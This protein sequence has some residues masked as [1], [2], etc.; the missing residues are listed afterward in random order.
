M[1]KGDDT[2][3][4]TMTIVG[5]E[6]AL[7]SVATLEGSL[8]A[9]NTVFIG[10]NGWVRSK[11]N[12]S[13]TD[14]LPDSG[15]WVDNI[16]VHKKSIL[17]YNRYNNTQ[18]ASVLSLVVKK[19]GEN[20]E[21][22]IEVDNTDNRL[23]IHTNANNLFFGSLDNNQNLTPPNFV[24]KYNKTY[25]I[26]NNNKKFLFS[27]LTNTPGNY[28]ID[29]ESTLRYLKIDGDFLINSLSGTW[30]D[31]FIDKIEFVSLDTTDGSLHESFKKINDINNDNTEYLRDIL[32]RDEFKLKF[33]DNLIY[34]DS[35]N[36]LTTSAGEGNKIAIFKFS[37]PNTDS[38]NNRPNVGVPVDLK[39]NYTFET[40]GDNSIEFNSDLVLKDFYSDNR[41]FTVS[42]LRDKPD[43]SDLDEKTK[44]RHNIVIHNDTLVYN[45][46]DL[47]KNP[48]I[49]INDNPGINK[50]FLLKYINK[51]ILGGAFF[52]LNGN[53][54]EFIDTTTHILKNE[55]VM[56]VNN[57][58]VDNCL[59]N[60]EFL[61]NNN[62]IGSNG[63][64]TMRYGDEI[65][66]FDNNGNYLYYD[67]T[68]NIFS[69]TNVVNTKTKFTIKP[70]DDK[71]LGKCI[72]TRIYPGNNYTFKTDVFY[73]YDTVSNI[74][75]G[76][77]EENKI[78]PSTNGLAIN[79]NWNDNYNY[80]KII[81]D[82]EFLESTKD[83]IVS[84]NTVNI[85]NNLFLGN[86]V[87]LLGSN[88]ALFK[89]PLVISKGLPK[90][91]IANETSKKLN[92]SI[93][94]EVLFLGNNN[95]RSNIDKNVNIANTTLK[96]NKFKINKTSITMGSDYNYDSN[97]YTDARGHVKLS[98]LDYPTSVENKAY[99]RFEISTLNY[100]NWNK[101]AMLLTET[102]D[103]KIK[104]GLRQFDRYQYLNLKFNQSTKDGEKNHYVVAYIDDGVINNY[105]VT[106]SN[107]PLDHPV[108]NI[109]G[110]IEYA[111]LYIMDN[112]TNTLVE[113]VGTGFIQNGM[114]IEFYDVNAT[115]ILDLS[116]IR[117]K[118]Q[119]FKIVG[120]RAKEV[121][122]IKTK[123]IK[124][125]TRGYGY[126]YNDVVTLRADSADG[127]HK[128]L[129]IR[130]TSIA[131]GGT[132][133]IESCSTT[134]GLDTLNPG[135]YQ[136]PNF[137]PS[138]RINKKSEIVNNA[139]VTDLSLA[140]LPNIEEEAN[141][142]L[143]FQGLMIQVIILEQY[144]L[145]IRDA[146]NLENL[147][148]QAFNNMALTIDGVDVNLSHTLDI[149]NT[150]T[151]YILLKSSNAT[152]D[153]ESSIIG[154]STNNIYNKL[155]I[156][157]NQFN[158]SA[159][160]QIKSYNETDNKHNKRVLR[161]VW[162]GRP[163]LINCDINV[164][165]QDIIIDVFSEGYTRDAIYEN[166]KREIIIPIT[167]ITRNDPTT[168]YSD[169]YIIDTDPTT[170]AADN[171]P[172]NGKF[173]IAYDL[174]NEN[175]LTKESIMPENIENNID[176]FWSNI[177]DLRIISQNNKKSEQIINWSQNKI[178][179]YLIKFNIVGKVSMEVLKISEVDINT[180]DDLLQNVVS[181]D[182]YKF[183]F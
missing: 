27:N 165:I 78:V 108:I 22:K 169:Y 131:D 163:V 153:N 32:I 117:I 10:D 109:Q 49:A 127:N 183:N 134:Q 152:N 156:I 107:P 42:S 157:T 19:Q 110:G 147:N 124:N 85:P 129:K 122:T 89:Y 101:E 140:G 64:L 167:I 28:N 133:Y 26:E 139:V 170:N 72:E 6:E 11:I 137:K 74:Y 38:Q 47:T 181:E 162:D 144:M 103:L 17:K 23:K 51:Q 93:E 70:D 120:A 58:L 68:L 173:L 150:T 145:I 97:R 128:Y 83:S 55:N 155:P 30:A 65:F 171:A 121:L 92:K 76:F 71:L 3:N 106:Q 114:E 79:F 56:R 95:G 54:K 43:N 94:E 130:I 40:K 100:G 88:K 123:T 160:F 164:F 12:N 34:I 21:Y 8:T 91:P 50:R 87:D 2:P 36:F 90:E 20:T 132:Y 41:L 149:N 18:Y 82:I 166:V 113:D 4:S 146:T 67:P 69:F 158:S 177:E 148:A 39:N 84:K 135:N 175:N 142:V 80:K 176:A 63:E 15:V 14:R 53:T 9:K 86:N 96:V 57:V 116:K 48:D 13:L 159:Y 151:K 143:I 118:A 35:N 62:G 52:R 141:L 29:I 168:D 73:L 136:N 75:V 154:G 179:N 138:I 24:F 180:K 112:I 77:N 5:G 172:D 33:S 119:L 45:T 102:A 105:I 98:S 115:G 161:I 99:G 59:Q 25:T 7:T 126:N 182:N 111:T 46:L 81:K 60:I 104:G 37:Y 178:T 174:K 44:F 16:V 1:N 66:L 61:G 31:N 125:K